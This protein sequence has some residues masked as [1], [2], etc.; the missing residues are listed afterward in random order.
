MSY[1]FYLLLLF[2]PWKFDRYVFQ[3]QREDKLDNSAMF[4]HFIAFVGKFTGFAAVVYLGLMMLDVISAP[5]R[6]RE[7]FR[8]WDQ[9]WGIPVILLACTFGF[10]SL[11]SVLRRAEIYTMGR[12]RPAV[13]TEKEWCKESEGGGS[14]SLTF[15]YQVGLR[16]YQLHKSEDQV[17]GAMF[18]VGYN[19]NIIH[20]RSNPGVAF[21][22]NRDDFERYCIHKD[23]V[24]PE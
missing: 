13:L 3:L 16:H 2:C 17:L 15:S 8:G 18:Q 1:L 4:R 21:L 11:R 22:Y 7:L 23:K 24:L 10:F 14:F 5:W 12:I 19:F 20:S 9:L 6:E